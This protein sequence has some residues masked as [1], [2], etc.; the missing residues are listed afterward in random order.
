MRTAIL[1][2][3]TLLPL[4]FLIASVIIPEYI[5]NRSYKP[6]NLKTIE[7]LQLSLI[8]GALGMMLVGLLDDLAY[9]L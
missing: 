1:I 9:Q 3:S 4:G 6:G 5:R 2:L 7:I 8:Y